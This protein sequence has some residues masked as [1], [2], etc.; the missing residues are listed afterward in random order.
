[1]HKEDANVL[2]N[3]FTEENIYY[4]KT[5]GNALLEY[6]QMIQYLNTQDEVKIFDVDIQLFFSSTSF[7]TASPPTNRPCMLISSLACSNHKS[8][9]NHF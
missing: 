6:R 1:M 2:A 5:A 4:V 7:S 8:Y 9:S 3:Q